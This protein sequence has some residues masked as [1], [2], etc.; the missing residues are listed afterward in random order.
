MRYVVEFDM[1]SELSANASEAIYR[2]L[3]SRLGRIDNFKVVADR[4]YVGYIQE[5]GSIV[6]REVSPD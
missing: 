3:V 6:C 5:N 2:T 1:R 4:A